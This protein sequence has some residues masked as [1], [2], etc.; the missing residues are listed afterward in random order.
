MITRPD[1]DRNTFMTDIEAVTFDL[2]DTLIQ[3]SPG[4]AARVVQ[5][6]VARIAEIL[7]SARRPYSIEA[8]ETAHAETGLHLGSIWDEARDVSVSY[9]VRFML[10]QLGE[11]L[12]EDVG[13][14]AFGEILVAYSESMLLHPPRL[15]PG[16]KE[17]LSQV[18]DLVPRLGLISN[19]GKTPGSVLRKIMSRMDIL[20]FFDTTT[21]SD[22]TSVRK[23]GPEIFLKTLGD[24]GMEPTKT[25]HVGDDPLTDI[26]GAQN[27][28]MRTVHVARG[29]EMKGIAPDRQVSSLAEVVPAIESLMEQ[30]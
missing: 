12:S 24:L 23:P 28:G 17:A 30:D 7:S 8:I 9:Q 22:E 10:D 5:A 19:T 27:V 14:E 25:V 13:P 21:F 6:R 20:R 29:K 4:G 3:E 16:A 18:R 1:V 26:K 11:G 2:W 15:L